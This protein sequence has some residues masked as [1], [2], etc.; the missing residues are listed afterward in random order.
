MAV[1][2]E[3]FFFKDDFDAVLDFFRFY[4]YDTNSSKAIAKIV[5]GEK[6]YLKWSFYFIICI[7]HVCIAT[8]Y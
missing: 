5:T 4:G 8:A 6:N 1:C 3:N 2:S 7:A